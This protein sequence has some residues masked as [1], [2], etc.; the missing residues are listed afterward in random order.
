MGLENTSFICECFRRLWRSIHIQWLP[1]SSDQWQ[2]YHSVHPVHAFWP[3]QP[4]QQHAGGCEHSCT[5]TCLG[6]VP[7]HKSLYP[8]PLFASVCLIISSWQMMK[9]A[10]CLTPL[11][12]WAWVSVLQRQ[13]KRGRSVVKKRGRPRRWTGRRSMSSSAIS[14]TFCSKDTTKDRDL[15]RSLNGRLILLIYRF[16]S[17]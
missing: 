16:S 2:L 12:R 4:G 15:C 7:P 3:Q 1:Q 5:V 14:E 17:S 6:F 8:N 11:P 13:K 10:S 9:V